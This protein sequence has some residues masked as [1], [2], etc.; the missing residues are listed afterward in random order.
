MGNNGNNPPSPIEFAQS[1]IDELAT[2]MCNHPV[3]ESEDEAR[4]AK[5]HIDRARAALVDIE[6]ERVKQ[7]TPLNDEVAKINAEHKRYHNNDKS[8]PGLFDKV[9]MALVARVQ[10]FMLVEEARRKREAEHARLLAEAAEKAAREAEA[11]EKE[12]HEDASAGL[13]DLDIQEATIQADQAF[14]DYQRASRFAKLAEKETKVRV[15]GGFGRSLSIKDKEILVVRDWKLAI[16]KIG[17]TDNIRHAILSGARNYRQHYGEMPPG[18]EVT[19]E[20]KV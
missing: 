4:I 9:L 11:R 14:E 8:K 12:I 19:Y 10:S 5:L 15:A 3:I 16:D 18:I 2:W 17:L 7:V 6:V 1:V 20:R 13:C